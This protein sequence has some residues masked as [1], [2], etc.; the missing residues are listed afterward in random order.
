MAEPLRNN[1][2]LRCHWWRQ[3]LRGIGTGVDARLGSPWISSHSNIRVPTAALEAAA[4]AIIFAVVLATRFFA[5]T[6]KCGL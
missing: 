4:L 3:F 6:L 1:N 5:P 2:S